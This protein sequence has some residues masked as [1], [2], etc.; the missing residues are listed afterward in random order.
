MFP[1]KKRCIKHLLVIESIHCIHAVM[2]NFKNLLG[3][4]I[5]K[6]PLVSGTI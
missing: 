1:W 2:T 5:S 6:L 3:I 4:E